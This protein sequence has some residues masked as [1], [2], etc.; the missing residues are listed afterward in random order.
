MILQAISS[1]IRSHIPIIK[2]GVQVWNSWRKENTD[3][4]PNLANAQLAKINL[5]GIN[6]QNADLHEANLREAILE[7]A[8]LKNADLT[9]AKLRRINLKGARISGGVLFGADLVRANLSQAE[10]KDADLRNATLNDADLTRTVLSG[11]QVYGVSV[12]NAR[13]SEAIQSNLKLS[14]EESTSLITTDSIQ[15]AV[16]I[17]LLLTGAGVRGLIDTLTSKAVLL[18]GR[19][20]PERKA[21]LDA[22]RDELRARNYV[23]ILFDFDKPL[24]RDLTETIVLLAHLSRFIVADIT[25]PKNIPYE[26]KHIVPHTPSVPIVP[27]LEKTG[28]K[29][30]I[31]DD[32][33]HYPWV[34]EPHIYSDVKELIG[35][36]EEDVIAPAEAK[37]K[38]ILE[39]RE[40]LLSDLLVKDHLK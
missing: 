21:V 38:E 7:G 14:D 9:N 24:N 32:Y 12:W 8:D 5:A 4:R 15:T 19:F 30:F 25:A 29:N 17:H 26:L 37:I 13:L 36:I 1:V 22:L 28:E 2:R 6:L 16:V 35:T 33:L 20:T 10:I 3:T 40:V 23:P 39:R 11:C 18:L 27:L 31:F 34:L